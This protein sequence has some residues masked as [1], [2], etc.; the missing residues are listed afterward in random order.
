MNYVYT[1]KCP[2]SGKIRY[3]GKSRN[4][5][6]RLRQHIED[7]RNNTNTEKKHWINGLLQ[8]GKFPKMEIV[9]KHPDEAIARNKEESFCMKNI[10]TI[11]NIHNPGRGKKDLH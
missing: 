9:F 3:V 1:L 4:P 5:K 10:S 6:S 2:I 11:F 8:A 7:S